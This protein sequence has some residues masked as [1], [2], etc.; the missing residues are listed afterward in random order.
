MF[1]AIT[2]LGLVSLG[3]GPLGAQQKPELAATLARIDAA[4]QKFISAQADV[5]KDLYNALIKETDKQNGR[6]YFLRDHKGG[7][8]QMGLMAY[9][10]GG[11]VEG[12]GARLV[13]YK[14][15]TLRDYNP[16]LKCFDS[17][18]SGKIETFL[19]IGFGGSGQDLNKAW[20]ITDLGPDTIAGV[21]AEKLDLVPRDAGVKS[22]VLHVTLWLDLDRDVS[23]QQVFYSPTGD[24]QTAR[25]TNIRL[26]GKVDL[27]PFEIKGNAC[28]K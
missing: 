27:K 8:T 1:R 25:Y 6:A 15:G 26:N 12:P 2:V 20:A 24:T 17:V 10:P 16:S 21:K 4:S 11:K 18:R 19:T 13:E 14:N 22:N 7:A 5:E 9:G 28:G 23:L 3:L